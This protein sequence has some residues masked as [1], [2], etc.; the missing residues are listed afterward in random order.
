MF[1]ALNL[2]LPTYGRTVNTQNEVVD[3]S[4]ER[5]S[6]LVNTSMSMKG[7]NHP[8]VPSRPTRPQVDALQIKAVI[9]SFT[10]QLSGICE[11]MQ[12]LKEEQSGRRHEGIACL[13]ATSFLSSSG[14]RSDKL[15]FLT[16]TFWNSIKSQYV[17]WN[18]FT[19]GLRTWWRLPLSSHLQLETYLS[20]TNPRYVFVSFITSRGNKT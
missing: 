4:T 15:K 7:R 8:A 20:H 16:S 19:V 18:Y 12:E 11:V 17:Y 1:W 14:S 6:P 2:F 3:K 5:E 13:R 9:H 10:Q